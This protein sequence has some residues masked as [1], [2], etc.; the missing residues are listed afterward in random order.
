MMA[1]CSWFSSDLSRRGGG[2]LSAAYAPR[3]KRHPQRRCVAAVAPFCLFHP[4]ATGSSAGRHHCCIG[5]CGGDRSFFQPAI[6]AAVPDLVRG[7]ACRRLPR[8]SRAP[9]RSPPARP[10][11]L[12]GRSS[13]AG[14]A[15][16]VLINAIS[17]WVC[18][19]RRV[20]LR[21]RP[22][23]CEGKGRRRLNAIPLRLFSHIVWKS[24]AAAPLALRC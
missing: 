7:N 15:H 14:R 24:R 10:R 6:S 18:R 2:P 22:P 3:P 17:D 9:F 12:A 21:C 13:M 19:R 8:C 20:F 4:E 5:A 23:L 16:H 1:D 11:H